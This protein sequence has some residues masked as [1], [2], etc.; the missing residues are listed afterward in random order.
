MS[1]TDLVVPDLGDFKEV[2]VVDVLV[3]PGDQV[4][5][6]T[7]LVTLETDKASMDV[8][9]TANGTIAEVLVKRG[10]KIAKGSVIA[11]IQA[12]AAQ[13]SESTA[14]TTDSEP[15]TVIQPAAI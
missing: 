14:S 15:S 2:A 3:K 5:V 8:P 11:R 12:T 6:D 13:P 7:A 10:D 1:L 9:S 4:E